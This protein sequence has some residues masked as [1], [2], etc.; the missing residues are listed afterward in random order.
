MDYHQLI[1]TQFDLSTHRFG[2]PQQSGTMTVLPV[3]G[4]NND[5]RF[6]APLSGLKL[7]QV[8]GYGNM[9]LS[10]PAETGIAIAPLHMGY[11]QDRAQ[12]HALCRSAFIAAGQ[13]LMFEDACCVQAAQGGYLEG[14]DQWFFIL[15]L[16]LRQ[17][18]LQLRGKEDYSKLWDAIS[19]LNEQFALPNRGHLEQ[20][21]SR[22]RAFLTQYQSRLELL[23]H[24]TG[25]VFFIGHK[26]A[27]V[28]IAPNA[29]Y[30]QE[31]WMP[32]VCFCYG[33]AAM[34]QEKDVEVNKS[35]VPFSASNLK[36]LKEQLNQSRLERQE[37]VRNWLA[38]TPAEQFGI[39]E[40]ERFLSLRLQT[41]TGKNFAGQFVEEEGRLL[42]ASLFAKAGYLN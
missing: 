12:N 19:R 17:E 37:Q 22:K 13:K 24:Q 39:E 35:L 9:E 23:P 7:S 3:F 32:L 10:N 36:E 14:R 1:P 41:V 30:F 29:A 31:L 15:P 25:A 34:Y 40:E 5:G 21:L 27:G 42:Y 26:L 4:S 6:V 33:V 18:A 2:M 38:Q 20:I 16:P 28:E 11:I 8:R